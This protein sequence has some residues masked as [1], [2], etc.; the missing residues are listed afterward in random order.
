M[1]KCRTCELATGKPTILALKIATLER[2]E[3]HYIAEKN[4]P[5]GIKKGQK[6]L[7]TNCKHLK[8][9]RLVASRGVRPIDEVMTKVAG[10]RACK[11][12]QMGI[13]F[14]LLTTGRPMVDYTAMRPLLQFIG[15][16]K[17]AKRHWSDSVGWMLAECMFHQIEMKALDTVSSARFFS[18]S[19]DEVTS[20][21]NGSWIS[22]HCYVVQNSSKVPI[23]IMLEQVKEQA[24]STN[25]LEIILKAVKDKGGVGD[26]SLIHKL[27]SFGV[28]KFFPCMLQ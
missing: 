13:I 8:N 23:L 18:V 9:E 4:M 10:E 20:I 26:G 15:V 25:L 7:A 14:H 17:L 11:R 28:G 21:D 19:C 2:H 16:P 1:V 12:Q 6:Y 5:G 3:G 24:T 27:M 22:I